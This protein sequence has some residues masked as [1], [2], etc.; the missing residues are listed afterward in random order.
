MN[1]LKQ[2]VKLMRKG[3]ARS[4]TKHSAPTYIEKH[5]VF[6]ESIFGKNRFVVYL[7]AREHYIAHALLYK[8]LKRRYGSKDDRTRKML[9]A[10]WRM[11][12]ANINSIKRYY[13]S[14]LH[15]ALRIQL[16]KSMSGKNHWSNNRTVSLET[17]KKMSRAHKGRNLWKSSSAQKNLEVWKNADKLYDLW[18]KNDRPSD[19]KLAKFTNFSYVK[20][21]NICKKFKEGWIPL[22]DKEWLQWAQ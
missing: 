18:L 13:N 19:K 14:R 22:G 9:Y 17:R 2:Y 7:T 4:W 11:N 15:E 3:Q 20:L 12:N 16:S 1:Y 5:H 10:W 21:A 8:G 6:P